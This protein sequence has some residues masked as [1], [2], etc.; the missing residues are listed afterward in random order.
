MPTVADRSWAADTSFAVAAVDATHEAHVI[1]R[2]LARQ[3]RPVLAGHAAFETFSVLTRLPGAVRPTAATVTELLGQAFP[4][5]C[6][7][8]TDQ[9]ADLLGRLGAIGIEGG[10]VYDALIAEAARANGLALLTRDLRAR[11][12]Y[13]LIGVDYELVD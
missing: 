1:C 8:S 10:Q 6:W 13:E 3:R 4:H 2:D 9:Q 11:R 7:L 5:P 12:T